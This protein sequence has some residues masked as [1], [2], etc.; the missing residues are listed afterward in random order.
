M[1]QAKA[2]IIPDAYSRSYSTVS[3]ESPRA[4][5]NSEY[6]KADENSG[7]FSRIV[8]LDQKV[9]GNVSFCIVG[10]I[11]LCGFWCIMFINV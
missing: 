8:K 4:S 2:A 1:L 6:L 9:R 5:A 7:I 3:H 10:T 11:E